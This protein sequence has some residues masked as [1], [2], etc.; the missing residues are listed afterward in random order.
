MRNTGLVCVVMAFL[1]ACATPGKVAL[2]KLEKA[3]YEQAESLLNKSLEK[4]TINPIAHYVL[5]LLHLDSGFRQYNIDTSY[6][7]IRQALA[8]LPRVDEK[9]AKQ[10]DKMPLDSADLIAQKKEVHAAA[11]AVAELLN[12]VESFQ[13]FLDRHPDAPEVNLAIERRNEL[14]FERA[15]DEHTY[16]AYKNFIETY[17]AARQIQE[18]E[19]LYDVLLF[20]AK[21]DDGRLRNYV[22]FLQDHPNSPYRKQAEKNIYELATADNQLDSYLK[23]IEQY[24]D[25]PY[26]KKATDFLYHVYK[27]EK[28]PTG[29]KSI[30][31]GEVNDSLLQV[32]A[33]E[34]KIIYPVYEEGKYGFLD[35]E[36]NMIFP[37]SFSEIDEDLYCGGIQ[38]D[39][40]VV[41]EVA[42][43]R[44]IGKNAATIFSQ[45]FDQAED[46]GYGLIRVKLADRAGVIHKGGYDVLPAEYDDVDVVT[47]RFIKI[48]N[49]G[50]FGLYTFSGRKILEPAFE[51]IEAVGRFVVF[52]K[53]G[54]YAIS[55]QEALLKVLD[56]DSPRLVFKYDDLELIDQDH[57]LVYR[58]R[59]EGLIDK[60]LNEVI[61]PKNHTI[62]RVDGGWLLRQIN[63]FQVLADN[64]QPITTSN[65]SNVQHNKNWLA[66][67]NNGKWA[68]LADGLT[69]DQDFA[70]DS[71]RIM[72]QNFAVLIQDDSLFINFQLGPPA[73]LKNEYSARLIRPPSLPDS[74]LK[75]PEYLLLAGS[76]NQKLVFNQTGELILDGNYDDVQAIGYEYLILERNGRKGLADRSGNI[77]LN[78]IYDGIGNYDQGFVSLLRNRRFGIL[79]ANK[80]V[81]IEPRYDAMLHRYN[82]SLFIASRSGEFGLIDQEESRVTD[83][84]FQTVEYWN[85]T[86]MLAKKD[87]KWS[88][89]NFDEEEPAYKVFDNFKI[90]SNREDKKIIEINIAAKF[91]VLSNQKGEVMPPTFNDIINVGTA[92]EPVYL[93]EI[94]IRE[95]EFL[96]IVYY[97]ENGKILRKQAME[98]DEY[99]RIYCG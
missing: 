40:L 50:Q 29:F 38:K 67:K 51:A 61:L 87:D 93:G 10:L 65:Y 84:D 12:T 86:M 27:E 35:P 7:Y 47:N 85:D 8:D 63:N 3:K 94:N 62:Y 55:D 58:G 28:D 80:E 5:S 24:F 82:D 21:T 74:D 77:L 41:E 73:K 66:L 71:A 57:L 68:F 59:L 49:Q 37:L 20:E 36:G 54:Q 52:T 16:V 17:P 96:V 91:G 81:L 75:A 98:P 9:Q 43:R 18:A 64:Y 53:N 99:M 15:K 45:E 25:S 76:R 34:N 39:Y 11:F 88:L 69:A 2:K 32:I 42:G 4:D 79:N 33:L 95:A 72:G 44:I 26:L 6:Y 78:I 30:V 13:L 60:S 48:K 31:G 83:F 19:E 70:Y 92:E 89:Y 97:D 22:Q 14:A 90:I 56:E 23:F 1:V 46:I